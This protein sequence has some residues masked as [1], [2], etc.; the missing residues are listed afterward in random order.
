MGASVGPEAIRQRT[1]SFSSEAS[2]QTY[3][4]LTH[5]L[6]S[7]SPPPPGH[8]TRRSESLESKNT[9][10]LKRYTR[11]DADDQLHMR[12]AASENS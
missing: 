10:Q 9:L 8:G 7:Q 1:A 5:R 11:R 3:C 2:K 4:T 6:T 12:T